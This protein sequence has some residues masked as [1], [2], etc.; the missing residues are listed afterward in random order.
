[1]PCKVDSMDDSHPW[2]CNKEGQLLEQPLF[3]TKW[4]DPTHEIIDLYNH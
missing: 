3:L 4:T 2:L 1:L